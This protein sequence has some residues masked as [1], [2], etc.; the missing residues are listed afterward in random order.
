MI[1]GGIVLSLMMS[2]V[3]AALPD[4]SLSPAQQVI[5][6]ERINSERIHKHQQ[7]WDRYF[8]KMKVR[9]TL[10][11]TALA[12][13]VIGTCAYCM[14]HKSP[15]AK[16]NQPAPGPQGAA[17]N[18]DVEI[19]RLLQ[20]VVGDGTFAGWLKNSLINMGGMCVIGGLFVAL[21]RLA[22]P[23][24][25]GVASW[26]GQS[27][28]D[29]LVQLTRI[30]LANRLRLDDS[31]TRLHALGSS[32]DPLQQKIRNYMMHDVMIDTD[33]FVQSCQNWVG[34]LGAALQRASLDAAYSCQITNSLNNLVALINDAIEHEEKVLNGN[35]AGPTTAFTN[36]IYNECV[37]MAHLMDMLLYGNKNTPS[38]VSTPAEH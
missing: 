1:C 30:M 5:K 24:T 3:C 20:R 36:E 37:R 17:A 12:T 4:Q 38:P 15:E 13:A 10:E 34:F 27:P 14:L 31:C 26:W 8:T 33:A 7:L 18:H 6:L 25:T 22:T 19:L 21:D 23:I 2:A 35:S 9:T 11:Y 32:A 16:N 29:N 28:E